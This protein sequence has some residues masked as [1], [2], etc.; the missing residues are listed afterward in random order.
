[1]NGD[2]IYPTVRASVE[3]IL[4]NQSDNGAIIASPD[5]E[6]YRFCWLRDASFIAYALDQAGEHE[7]SARYHAWVNAAVTGIAGV[8]DEVIDKQVDG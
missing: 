3:A 4:Q 1:M 6:Q 8:I 2:H 7:A 5:F